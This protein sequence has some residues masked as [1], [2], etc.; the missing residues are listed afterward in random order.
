[1]VN[2]NLVAIE[3]LA[4][5]KAI[6]NADVI[7][8][9]KANGDTFKISLQSIAEY[10]ASLYNRLNANGSTLPP[11]VL[12]QCFI[13]DE[14]LPYY[15]L[16][17]LQGQTIDIS[18]D[19]PYYILGQVSYVGDARNGDASLDGFY[20]VNSSGQRSISGTKMVLPDGRGLYPRGAGANSRRFTSVNTPYDGKGVGSFGG[21]TLP[22]LAVAMSMFA[23]SS[24]DLLNPADGSGGLIQNVAYGRA[25]TVSGGYFRRTFTLY[26]QSNAG[27]ETAPAS[28]AAYNCIS[29]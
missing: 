1:M 11:G 9:T 24:G 20:K 2:K 10:A 4:F 27:N 15:R 17:K 14:W 12:V 23:A 8:I 28:L 7:P 19:S 29:Y 21:D 3:A 22:P 6:D 18:Q 26:L 13:S 5:I 25:A 16:L